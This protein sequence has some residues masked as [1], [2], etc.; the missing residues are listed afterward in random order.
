MPRDKSTYAVLRRQE[1]ELDLPLLHMRTSSPKHHTV[2]LFVRTLILVILS[3]G[4]KKSF[5]SNLAA[6]PVI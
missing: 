2:Q 3:Q 4:E 5:S 6:T 1:E